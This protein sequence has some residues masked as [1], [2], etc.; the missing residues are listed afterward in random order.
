MEIDQKVLALLTGVPAGLY[1]GYIHGVT[2]TLDL[3]G[4]G[5]SMGPEYSCN[6][7]LQQTADTLR[8]LQAVVG[9]Y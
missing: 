7:Q 2:D 1:V 3:G 9:L 6:S 4:R 5:S 8:H